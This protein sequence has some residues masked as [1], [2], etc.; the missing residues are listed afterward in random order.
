MRFLNGSVEFLN[1]LETVRRAIALR[2]D[3]FVAFPKDPYRGFTPT[4]KQ[5]VLAV[6]IRQFFLDRQHGIPEEWTATETVK[7][8]AADNARPAPAVDADSTWAKRARELRDEIL[9]DSPTNRGQ[10]ALA[11]RI[12]ARLKAERVT[13]RGGRAVSETTIIRHVLRGSK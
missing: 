10:K 13:G 6:S 3:D 5:V 8:V 11:A 12:G 2:P 7:T 9:R 4:E 1:R